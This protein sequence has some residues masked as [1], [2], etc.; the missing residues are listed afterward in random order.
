ML[1]TSEGL[2]AEAKETKW[3]KLFGASQAAY[4]ALAVRS[5]STHQG[6]RLAEPRVDGDHGGAAELSG[7]RRPGPSCAGP[8][9]SPRL[10]QP[11]PL[12]RRHGWERLAGGLVDGLAAKLGIAAPS[13]DT[14]VEDAA[15][16][17]THDRATHCRRS[18][19]ARRS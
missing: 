17:R 7:P 3:W 13:E 15:P 5:A 19:T 9:P 8:S 12:Q 1:T 10:R 6:H 14:K 18:S 11:Q 16:R 4:V 2:I